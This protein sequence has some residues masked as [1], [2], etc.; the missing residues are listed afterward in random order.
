[1][2][3]GCDG[4][5]EVIRRLER[6]LGVRRRT[7]EIGAVMMALN[8]TGT[9]A[10]LIL[11]MYAAKGRAVAYETL[12]SEMTTASF[13]NL[14]TT[15]CHIR[16]RAGEGLVHNIQGVGYQLTPKGMSMVLA[17]IE[18]LELQDAKAS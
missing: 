16:K 11:C 6:E 4:L 7:G 12:M 17:A 18:P 2:C 13:I 9:E 15:I 14:K 8:V 10:R 1:M 3:A 5:K